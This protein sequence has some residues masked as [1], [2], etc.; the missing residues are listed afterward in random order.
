MF[1]IYNFFLFLLLLISPFIIITRIFLGKEDQ[2]RFKE[3]YGFFAKNEKTIETIWIHG[4]SIGEILSIIP[5]IRK[6]EKDKKIKRILITSTTTS[7]AHIFSKFKFKKTIHQFYP[8]DFNLLTKYFINHWKPKLAIFIDSEIW[9]NM[10]KNLNKKN[11]PLIL[12]NA[13]ITKKSYSRWKFFPNFS[14]KI[15]EKI[16]LA[17]PQNME[18]KKYLKLLGTKEIKLIGNLKFFGEAQKDNIKN[19][20]LKKKFL[21]KIIFCAAST[22]K[23]EELFIG[24]VHKE[25]KS[26]IKN[27]ITIIIPRH[28]NRKKEILDELNNIGLNS[29]LHTSP[30]KLSRDTDI[31]LVDTYG[32]TTKFYSLSKLTFLGGSLVRHG[33]QN[34][35]EAAREGNYILYGPHIENFKEVYKILEKLKITTRVN[36]I[37]NMKYAVRQ[38]INFLQKNK[39]NKKLKYLGNKI[40]NK[41]LYEIK[42]FI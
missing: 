8:F 11:I 9:P 13:R 30:K 5:I 26:E 23:G 31:Y 16:T 29:Q 19:L 4:A 7:S 33:G 3:K 21:K 25:L 42:K 38:K 37:K 28:V 27:L 10:F 39:V 32:E 1:V 17:L 14:K 34:P 6:F 22:H 18:S 2:N 36:S 40:L 12:L 41:N 15:F 20:L 24:K 35:L